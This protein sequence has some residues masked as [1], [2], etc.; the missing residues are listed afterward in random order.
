MQRNVQ[1][2]LEYYSKVPLKRV[3][4]VKNDVIVL[5]IN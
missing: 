3:T 2:D 4:L 5:L 1:E